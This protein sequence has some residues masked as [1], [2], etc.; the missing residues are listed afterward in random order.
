MESPRTMLRLASGRAGSRAAMDALHEE[1]KACDTRIA[2]LKRKKHELAVEIERRRVKAKL[3]ARALQQGEPPP[4]AAPDD[5]ASGVAEAAAA[6]A[7]PPPPP[8][9]ASDDA[10]APDA[11]DP[12]ATVPAAMDYAETDDEM[13]TFQRLKNTISGQP[14]EGAWPER[15]RRGQEEV[16]KALDEGK[17]CLAVLPTGYG[18]SLI[19]EL[20][21]RHRYVTA[22]KLTVVLSPLRALIH[23]QTGR[24]QDRYGDE[25]A[26]NTLREF[27]ND[28][29]D[30]D[31]EEDYGDVEEVNDEEDAGVVVVGGLLGDL[32]NGSIEKRMLDRASRPA[33]VFTTPERLVASDDAPGPWKRAAQRFKL[34]LRRLAQRNELALVAFDEAHTSVDWVKWR[35]AMGCVGREIEDVLERDCLENPVPILALTGTLTR[36]AESEVKAALCMK[37]D[38]LIVRK[39]LDRPELKYAVE[40]ISACRER[41]KEIFEAGIDRVFLHVD[42]SQVKHYKTIIFVA[43]KRDTET[44]A[45]LLVERGARAFAYHAGL[46]YEER[47]KRMDAFEKTSG[48]FLVA[49]L[50]AGL[51]LD[52]P[53]VTLTAH[54]TV[55]CNANTLMQEM[56]RAGRAK[57]NSTCLQIYHPHMLSV[58]GVFEDFG[59]DSSA[60]GVLRTMLDMIDSGTC[61]RRALLRMIGEK[62]E[63]LECAGCDVC[64]PSLARGP[65]H[66]SGYVDATA[67]ARRLLLLVLRAEREGAPLSFVQGLYKRRQDWGRELSVSVANALVTKLLVQGKLRL[68]NGE[69][70]KGGRYTT[71]ATD[72]VAAHGILS[73]TETVL[74][75]PVRDPPPR[76]RQQR[77]AAQH[78]E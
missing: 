10:D 48:A 45:E 31:Y 43:T 69:G 59:G 75:R 52:N 23:Q 36:E 17:D 42:R 12:R 37:E 22:R 77:A 35:E 41:P 19:F 8:P 60:A 64:E 56:G 24:L 3:E 72:T 18:K 78:A 16:L 44:V 33:I 39:C 58:L 7:A 66:A 25:Y 71:L 27:T 6:D 38:A 67:A 21:A 34:V 40:D 11:A 13:A 76:P 62:D 46:A 65:G 50:A 4:A 2:Q 47:Q 54:F 49:T 15:P 29:G 20:H 9:A 68:G 57:T 26:V 5:D 30:V 1:F 70:V 74:V 28:D 61:R 55:R 63:A 53:N 51:G 73:R 14:N 32:P